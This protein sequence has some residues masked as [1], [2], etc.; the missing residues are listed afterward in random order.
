[1]RMSDSEAVQRLHDYEAI[2]Q[3]VAKYNFAFDS[4]DERAY[5]ACWT[6]DGFV[7]RRNSKPSC[8]GHAQL[9]ALARDFPVNGRHVTTDLVIDLDGDRAEMKNYMLYLDMDP[10]CEVSMFGVY[11]DKLVRTAEGWKFSER[12][13]EPHVIRES[14][15]S[16]AFM[17]VVEAAAEG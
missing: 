7:E 8:R 10:P 12:I 17:A 11:Y 6:E 9:A 15:T 5:I 13:F 3:L 14:E 16:A 1:M 2:R 4:R